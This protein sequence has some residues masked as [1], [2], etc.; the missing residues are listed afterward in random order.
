MSNEEK[1]KFFVKALGDARKPTEAEQKEATIH[2][3]NGLISY[4]E[5]M[6]MGMYPERD[7]YLEALRYALKCVQEKDTAQGG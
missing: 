7:F 3:L 4:H 1:P 5:R 6:T 2:I